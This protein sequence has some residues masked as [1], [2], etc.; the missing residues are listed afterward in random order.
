MAPCIVTYVVTMHGGKYTRVQVLKLRGSSLRDGLW[1]RYKGGV[2]AR[3]M[4]MVN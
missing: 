3:S 2:V 1:R 4:Y